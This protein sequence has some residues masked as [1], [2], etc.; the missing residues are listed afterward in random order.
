MTSPQPAV[1]SLKKS[2][3]L[4]TLLTGISMALSLLS[5][6]VVAA[7]F[8]AGAAMDAYLAASTLPAFLVTLFALAIGSTFLPVF[9]ETRIRDPREGWRVA[10]G[11]FNLMLP[12]VL[13]LCLAG[14]WGA[15]P[16]MRLLSP[17]LSA[18]DATV[19]AGL[20]RVLF[21]MAALNVLNELVTGV[22]YA[23]KKFARPFLL[24]SAGPVLTI[25]LVLALSDRLS[26]AS[27]A[28]AGL[29]AAAIQFAIGVAGLARLPD[30]RYSA[31][32]L[33]PPR[34]T[35]LILK[36]MLPL[37]ASML[38]YKSLPLFDRWAVSL[39]PVG[40]LSV[41]GYATKLTGFLQPL[42]VSGIAVSFYPLMAELSAR[43]DYEGLRG[44]MARSLRMLL[45]VSLPVAVFLALFGR[46]VVHA[47]LARGEFSTEAAT[48]T[49]KVFAL[50]LLSLPG[51]LAGSITGQG[52]YVLKATRTVTWMGLAET[53]LYVPLC[54]G[55][56]PVLGIYAIPVSQFFYFTVSFLVSLRILSRR[57][58]L[59]LFAPLGP[60]L[61]RQ[62][63]ALVAG[64]A[65]SLPLFRWL[66]ESLLSGVSS[67]AAAFAAYFL[68]A[69]YLFKVD[70]ARA[71]SGMLRNSWGRLSRRP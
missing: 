60:F 67:L 22:Y 2:V 71:F 28:L 35:L 52:F 18:P 12:A 5:S 15:H 31:P 45:F 65:V 20:L 64:L 46:P 36:A 16:L 70:E 38:V 42:L 50:C 59:N 26:I 17:G 63:P 66:P 40:S 58:G 29:L 54:L 30:F 25:V 9:T 33:S 8:G 14:M 68:A 13:L 34:G 43:G 39:L 41:L 37:L 69:R 10:S 32:S 57:I 21:P 6:L 56:L 11:L 3:S 48:R 23:R 61:A 55:L 4:I 53:A 24:K 1:P 7:R 44:S 49:Y 27:V 19:A 47:L 62:L 51:M